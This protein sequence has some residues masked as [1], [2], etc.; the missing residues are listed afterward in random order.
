MKSVYA[1]VLS[2]SIAVL[3]LSLVVF[4]FISRAMV[5]NAFSKDGELGILIA[6]QFDEA[7][8]V[9]QAEGQ[10]GLAAYLQVLNSSYPGDYY[11]ML[12][13]SNHD[14]ITGENRSPLAARANSWLSIFNLNFPPVF[15]VSS[16]NKPYKMVLI[17]RWRGILARY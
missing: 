15:S 14:L 10:N 13:Q 3:V 9:F 5:Y 1:K 2:W 11:Y 12:D 4:L 17:S 7:D 16:G 8:R 6:M